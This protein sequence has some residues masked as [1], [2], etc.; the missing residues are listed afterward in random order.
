MIDRILRWLGVAEQLTHL[1]P[2]DLFL[3]GHSIPA[4]S[5]SAGQDIIIEQR[6]IE[7]QIRSY[8]LE[9]EREIDALRSEAG[10]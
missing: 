5:A 8:I 2:I 7:Q 3:A 1:N 4:I 10:R 6:R 9:L